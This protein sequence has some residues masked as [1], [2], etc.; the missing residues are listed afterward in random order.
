[1]FERRTA[2]IAAG[3]YWH[4]LV[5]ST[6]PVPLAR[7]AVMDPQ[8]NIHRLGVGA[9]QPFVVLAC[10]HPHPAP[11]TEPTPR[12]NRVQDSHLVTFAHSGA[13]FL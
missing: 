10:G 7:L 11:R 6:R 4:H 13:F 2:V 1:M 8:A 5:L 9:V 12:Q 3:L